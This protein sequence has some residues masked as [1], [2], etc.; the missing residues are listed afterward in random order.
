MHPYSWHI[1]PQVVCIRINSQCSSCHQRFYII[2]VDIQCF[3]VFIHGFHMTTMFEVVHTC[4]DTE[5]HTNDMQ[6]NLSLTYLLCA[7]VTMRDNWMKH[8]ESAKPSTY[9][10]WSKVLL[11]H[12]KAH[13][14]DCFFLITEA[15]SSS[16]KS[17][18]KRKDAQWRTL[19][20]FKSY[21]SQYWKRSFHSL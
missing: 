14:A 15:K 19:V 10:L 16:W 7:V 12:F 13:D 9:F 18:L 8:N 4:T 1:N 17:L 21:F 6:K 20:T 3:V 2:S 5:R 11:Y